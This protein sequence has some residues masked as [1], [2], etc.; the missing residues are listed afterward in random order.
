MGLIMKKDIFCYFSEI[1]NNNFFYPTNKKGF[2]KSD[3]EYEILPWLCSNKSLQAIKIKNKEIVS[4]TIEENNI[5][6]KNPE[7]YSVVWIE[8][9]KLPLSSA[10]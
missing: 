7:N 3:A 8:K 10:G 9:N 5:T 6:I 2:I 1:G 4:L